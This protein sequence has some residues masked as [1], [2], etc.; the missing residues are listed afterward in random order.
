MKK[1]SYTAPLR[2]LQLVKVESIKF[3]TNS[4]GEYIDIL[5]SKDNR[6]QHILNNV[7]DD[8]ENY[9]IAQ[10]CNAAT[11]LRLEDMESD[12]LIKAITGKE[13]EIEINPNG[14]HIYPECRLQQTN[15]EDSI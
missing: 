14:F 2:G 3:D 5:V 9:I 4:R 7:N 10:L 15:E 1:F 11:Q 12:K 8:T 6:S 13:L